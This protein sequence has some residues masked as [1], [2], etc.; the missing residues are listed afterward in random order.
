MLSTQQRLWQRGLLVVG[1]SGLLLTGCDSS[2]PTSDTATPVTENKENTT[3]APEA[4]VTM[5]TDTNAV[6]QN[7]EAN[8]ALPENNSPPT[9]TAPT[10]T[11]DNATTDAPAETLAGTQITDMRYQN[12]AGEVI[13]VVYTTSPSGILSA[14]LTMPNQAPMTLDAPEGQGN[15]PTYRSSDGKTQL[16]SHGGGNSIDVIVNDTVTS[17]DATSAD[18]RVVTTS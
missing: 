6:A 13:S 16:V 11:A 5:D 9:D 8:Q 14:R 10:N 4:S 1:M 3:T 15:N 12:A 2:E 7:T 18:A 17:F